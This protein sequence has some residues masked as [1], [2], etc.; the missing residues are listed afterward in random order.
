[1]TAAE[2]MPYAIGLMAGL[3]LAFLM[4]V[5]FVAYCVWESRTYKSAMVQTDYYQPEDGING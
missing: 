1:M 5:A 4:F 2:I 3:T